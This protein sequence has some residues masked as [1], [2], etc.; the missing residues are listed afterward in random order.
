VQVLSL[1]AHNPGPETGSGNSTYLVPGPHPL[2]IDA[3][4]GDPRHL[5]AV[6][7]ALGGAPLARVIVTHNHSDHAAG[8]TALAAR[9]PGATFAKFPWP[10]RDDRYAVHWAAL[11]DGQVVEAGGGRL[12]VV[13]T[14]GHAPDHVCLFDPERK[15][16][17][18]GDLL[19]RGSTVV[20]P[21]SA[22]GSL[23]RYLASLERVRALHPSRV[24]PAHGEPIDHAEALIDAYVEHRLQRE[25]RILAAL[26][27]GAATPA[28]I[29]PLAYD[30]LRPELVAF[31]RDSVLAHLVKLEEE[32]RVRRE[33]ER[34]RMENG[35]CRMKN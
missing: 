12:V 21:A 15:V 6:A 26:A 29:V 10:E 33:G 14:P 22:G 23:A 31:A 1:P 8:V 4:V 30:D 35:E 25:G 5:D 19:V 17:F 2:L 34:W 20:I 18:G 27:G 28:A 3:G 7:R 32:G 16:L 11:E 9:W 24:L 13:W